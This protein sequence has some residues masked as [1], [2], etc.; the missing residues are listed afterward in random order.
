MAGKGN[1]YIG[2]DYSQIE[3]RVLAM[4]C[5]DEKLIE[6]F[7]NG[8][9]IHMTVAA[10]MFNVPP[11]E[12]TNDMRR[13]AK[14][15]NFGI[16]YGMGITALQKNLG[17]TRAEAQQFHDAY[18]AA[19]PKIREYLESTKDYA[20]KHGYTETVFGRR[21]YYPGINA[22]APF[23]RA[24]AERTATNA[25]IQGTNADIVKLAIKLID[26]DL[27]A[28]GLIDKAHLILQI[29]DELVYEVDEKVA[30]QTQQII[31][32]AMNNVFE[33]SPIQVSVPLVPLAVSVGTGKR[34]DD[35][36]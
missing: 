32:D 18:F 17:T 12:V 19:F 29:H 8:E 15:I 36:K 14:V 6:T 27:R 2:S 24:I 20:R 7:R 35:L 31:V 13:K 9:D 28:A 16:L 4:L 21:R 26:E 30:E 25:P 1:I 33:R 34:L 23:L 5:G 3:L 10:S 11:A 22:S